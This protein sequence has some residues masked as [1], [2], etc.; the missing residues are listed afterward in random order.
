MVSVEIHPVALQELAQARYWCDRRSPGLGMAF[1]KAMDQAI[2]SLP[3]IT[4]SKEQPVEDPHSFLL[5]HFP[6]QIIYRY[7]HTGIQIVALTVAQPT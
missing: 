3:E 6:F 4:Q 7:S 5:A 1:L 2:V